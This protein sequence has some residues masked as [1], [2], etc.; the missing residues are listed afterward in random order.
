MGGCLSKPKNVNAVTNQHE[1]V[2]TVVGR[3]S[4]TG[5]ISESET[6]SS[7]LNQSQ[8]NL[9]TNSLQSSNLVP[10]PVY[11]FQAFFSTNENDRVV[12]INVFSHRNVPANHA[13]VLPQ[14]VSSLAESTILHNIT[15]PHEILEN[16]EEDN[17]RLLV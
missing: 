4:E 1:L 6:V 3:N 16:I 13:M 9:S 8:S 2:N 11:Y 12:F 17:Q 7:P 14:S 5:A 10:S 15:I